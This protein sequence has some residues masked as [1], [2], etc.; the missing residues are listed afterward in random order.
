[1]DKHFFQQIWKFITSVKLAV[2]L[3]IIIFIASIVGTFFEQKKA[4]EN[5][6]NNWWFLALIGLF[7]VNLI[8][9][10][11]NRLRAFKKAIL[12]TFIS[13]IGILII[14]AGAVINAIYSVEGFVELSEKQSI[15]HFILKNGKRAKLPFSIYL[16]DFSLELYP[17]QLWVY[18]KDSKTTRNF[19]IK[20]GDVIEIADKRYN[21]FVNKIFNNCSV[22]H[23]KED[24]TK[25]FNQLDN[26]AIEI[27]IQGPQGTESMLLATKGHISAETKDGLLALAYTYN[28]NYEG[29]IKNFTSS[30][31]IIE[32]SFESLTG[33]VSVN[34][35]LTY[36]GYRIYQNTYN[37]QNL[38]WTGLYIVKSPGI[39]I[40]YT[41]FVLIFIG[42]MYASFI[43]P[44]IRKEQT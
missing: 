25:P 23:K 28:R 2:I 15:D 18:F 26:S 12:G 33:K 32:N 36:N 24:I 14:L 5:I 30:I 27:T 42:L 3:G 29:D 1:M 39:P 17:P 37:P 8:A 7:T 21:I 19:S 31:K 10:T 44:I 40:V 6:Y 41:G 4:I 43:R 16:E 20:E 35:P 38:D 13:H 22:C 9:C 34:H 11:I